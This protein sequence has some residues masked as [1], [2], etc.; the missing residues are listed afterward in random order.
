MGV[1]QSRFKT[2]QP[3]YRGL[4]KTHLKFDDIGRLKVS[5]WKKILYAN[6]NQRKGNWLY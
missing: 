5:G 1:W 2:K 3:N 4:E 6:I